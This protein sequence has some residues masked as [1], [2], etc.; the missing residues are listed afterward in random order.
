MFADAL[1]D[2]GSLLRRI[3][4]LFVVAAVGLGAAACGDDDPSDEGGSIEGMWTFTGD[5]DARYYLYITSEMVTSYSATGTGEC[6]IETEFEIVDVDGD[7]Y[8]LA[9]GELE[10]E[11]ELRR[12]GDDLLVDG[13]EWESSNVDPDDLELC[14]PFELP[15]CSTLPEVEFGSSVVGD[16]ET[17]DP[18]DPFGAYYDGYRIEVTSGMPDP[19]VVELNSGA[20]D[21]YLSVYD[22]AGNEIAFNDDWDATGTD[23]RIDLSVE[24]GCYIVMATSWNTGE[25]GQYELLFY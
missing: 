6:V 4:P 18:L 25:T 23:S 11:L 9:H 16:L 7:T 8:T 5:D 12:S 14:E 3:L 24:P 13:L 15:A 17:S 2:A 22:E 20:F 1:Q 19:V 10:Q 21:A